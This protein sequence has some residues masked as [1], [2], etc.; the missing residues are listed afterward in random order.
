MPALAP[1]PALGTTKLSDCLLCG[2]LGTPLYVNLQD[3]LFGAPGDWQMSKCSNR[4][5]Q[6]V[7]LNPMPDPAQLIAAYAD[8]YTHAE[9]SIDAKSRPA[10]IYHAIKQAY[11]ASRYGYQ[12]PAASG[13][14]RRLGWLLYFFPVR[15]SAVDEEMRRLQAHPNGR[16][17]DVGCGTGGWLET[18]RDLG[19]QVQ[20]IDF[21]KDAVSV[22][23]QRGLTVALGS[24]E[25]Q[26]YPNNYFDIVTLNHVIEHLPHPVRTLTECHRILKNGG[27]LIVYTPNTAG[28]GHRLLKDNWRG[29]EPPRHLYLF[30]RTSLG[31]ALISSGFSDFAIDTVNSSYVWRQSLHLALGHT[32]AGRTF[33]SKLAARILC[34]VEQALLTFWSSGGECLAVR[35]VKV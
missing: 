26:N 30:C 11:V 27:R 13:V 32:A 23:S 21:D 34:G 4:R 20:G 33:G 18:M 2:S 12:Y 29:L 3:R 7:W 17:L 22:A 16:L 14:A 28:F 8:Y 1:S 10:K 15:R 24:V 19:W 9:A 25:E 31:A 35:A 6:L 5:C